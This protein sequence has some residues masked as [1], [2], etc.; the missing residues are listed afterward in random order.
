[1]LA[2]ASC[3]PRTELS[4]YSS[5]SAERDDSLLSAA[6][7]ATP[8]PEILPPLASGDAAPGE[9]EAVT[10]AVT[11]AAEDTAASEASELAAPLE[12]DEGVLSDASL[13]ADECAR[14]EGTLEPGSTVCLFFNSTARVTWQAAALACESRGSTLVAIKTRARDDFL[15]SLI[16]ST[17]T[18]IGANDPGTDPAANDYVW[19]DGTAVDLMLGTWAAGEP[20]D[21][22]DQFCVMKT[23]GAAGRANRAAPWRDRP[24]SELEAYVCEQTL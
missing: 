7:P 9:P 18:W 11:D 5:S 22:A 24:C 17:A 10:D 3:L 12:S 1:M 6:P 19:R 2:A 20:D 15:T 4:V 21:S 8:S 13:L 14:T 23:I 16:G